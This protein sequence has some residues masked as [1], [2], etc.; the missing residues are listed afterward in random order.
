M[1]NIKPK[2]VIFDVGGV[3]YDFTKTIQETATFLEISD[4]ELLGAY[5]VDYKE[6]EVSK[7]YYKDLVK[8]MVINLGKN[9]DTEKVVSLLFNTQRY[10][11]DTLLLIK[12]LHKAGYSLALLTNTWHGITE[13][14]TAEL[15]EFHLF[16]KVF[17]SSAVGI[18]KPNTEIFL[19]VEE[20]I[21]THNSEILFV[22]DRDEN[23]LI[24]KNMQW[25]TFHYSLGTD[26]GKTSNNKLRKMLLW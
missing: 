19:Y 14:V 26:E 3:L 9:H 2:W 22:D 12:E 5:F 1:R 25:Q 24:A 7:R 23:I 10:I 20:E 16:D 17:A 11:P 18:R 6:V 4:K 21:K 13:E 8:K 15:E